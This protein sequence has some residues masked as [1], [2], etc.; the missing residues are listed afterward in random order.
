M[1]GR[2]GISAHWKGVYCV[3]IQ[4]S[5][6]DCHPSAGTLGIELTRGEMEAAFRIVGMEYRSQ[7]VM[8]MLEGMYEAGAVD[9]RTYL[10]VRAD[11]GFYG[12]VSERYEKRADSGIPYNDSLR[13]AVMEVLED[14]AGQGDGW[15]A[16]S[17]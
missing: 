8:D 11:T 6:E 12:A 2:G 10:Q 5:W 7:D 14:R 1:R 15:E 9:K 16:T 3:R 13:S 17:G 4:R